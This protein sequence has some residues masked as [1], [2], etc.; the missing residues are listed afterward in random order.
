MEKA[1]DDNDFDGLFRFGHGLKG[2]ARNYELYE[3]GNIFLEI[4][5]ASKENKM[6][7]IMF[8]LKKA[9]NYLNSVNVEFINKG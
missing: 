6:E 2:S 8:N 7:T 3:L 5:N 9:K 1:L 4:E